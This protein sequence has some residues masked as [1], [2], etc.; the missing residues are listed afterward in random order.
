M[1]TPASGDDD[2]GVPF[3]GT[4]GNSFQQWQQ[5]GV[6][7]PGGNRPSLNDFFTQGQIRNMVTGMIGA[8]PGTDIRSA[9]DRG[10]AGGTNLMSDAAWKAT[11]RD[12]P[13]STYASHAPKSSVPLLGGVTLA[14]TRPTVHTGSGVTQSPVGTSGVVISGGIGNRALFS[15]YGTGSSRNVGMGSV[16]AAQRYAAGLMASLGGG[17]LPNL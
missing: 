5:P 4:P 11:F 8:K 16:M 7:P 1:P 13:G 3:Y 6:A 12:T 10:V 2:F 14:P 15:G 9:A 17:A